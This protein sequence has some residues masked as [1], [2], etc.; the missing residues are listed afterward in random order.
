M[1]KR[2]KVR[3]DRLLMLVFILLLVLSILGFSGYFLYQ[4]LSEKESKQNN[5]NQIPSSDINTNE[6]EKEIVTTK[7]IDYEVYIDDTDKLGFNFVVAQIELQSSFDS[8]TFGLENLE[9][10]EKL[11]LSNTNKYRNELLNQ[12]YDFSKLDVVLDTVISDT[13]KTTIKVFIPY[14]TEKIELKVFNTMDASKFDIDLRKNQVAITNLKLNG[15]ENVEID[16]DISIFVSNSTISTKMIHNEEEFTYPDSLP[17]YT[18]VLTVNEISSNTKIVDAKFIKDGDSEEH[19]C[20][21]SEYESIKYEN[22]LNKELS[23]GTSGALF[24]QI[25]SDDNLISYDGVLLIKLS[26]KE[27]WVKIST[28]LR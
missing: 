28:E 21:D 27:D 4:Y 2:N 11:S 1:A 7:L 15:G 24:F 17:V 13:N 5:N 23:V 20:M 26:N 12:G 25:P 14:E 9:T 6:E 18:F 16:S 19:D 10:S 3:V 8:L 22:I